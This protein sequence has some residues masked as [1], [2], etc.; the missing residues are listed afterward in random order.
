[1]IIQADTVGIGKAADE[2]A[3]SIR[4]LEY[5]RLEMNDTYNNLKQMTEGCP[6]VYKGAVRLKKAAAE[7]DVY[8]RAVSQMADVLRR[9][10]Y[11]YD[12][13]EED[14]LDHEVDDK[15]AE[16][17]MT[18]N[19]FAEIKDALNKVMNEAVAGMS[20][21]HMCEASDEAVSK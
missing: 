19:S 20:D 21:E 6:C 11:R 7:L 10:S 2:F 17:R 4:E 15:R 5:V 1:M 3:S 16:D 12:A 8:V 14:I 9:A 13:A 18:D